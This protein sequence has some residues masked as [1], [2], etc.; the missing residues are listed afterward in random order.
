MAQFIER[1]S[2]NVNPVLICLQYLS[3]KSF[4]CVYHLPKEIMIPMRD[5]IIGNYDFES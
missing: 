1:N 3:A 2:V 5:I 4:G